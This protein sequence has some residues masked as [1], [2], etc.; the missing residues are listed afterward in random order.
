MLFWANVQLLLMDV[1]LFFV[2]FFSPIMTCPE[3]GTA[4]VN[5]VK[6]NYVNYRGN[7]F[8]AHFMYTRFKQAQAESL[9]CAKPNACFMI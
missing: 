3:Q 9:R 8:N 1:Q 5:V 6:V 2:A 4:G 7:L